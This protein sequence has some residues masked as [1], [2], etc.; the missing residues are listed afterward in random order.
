MAR[1]REHLKNAPIVEAVIDFRVVPRDGVSSLDFRELRSQVGAMYADQ[2]PMQSI[3]AKFGLGPGRFTD[4]R[5]IQ[6]IGVLF[7]GESVVAQFRI[8]G[9]TFNKLAPYTSWD[10]VFAEALRLWRIYVEAAKPVELTR[11]AVRYVNRLQLPNPAD[12][13]KYLEVPPALPAPISHRMQEYLTRFVIVDRDRDA[14][15]VIIQALERSLEPAV[16]SLLFDI[17]AF[18]D[19]ALAPDDSSIPEVFQRLRELKNEIFFATLT[20]TTVEMYA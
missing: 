10:E 8:D 1:R 11:V 7:K 19:D 12:L 4:S 13:S 2:N 3:E 6:D 15:A 14:S 20:E 16:M 17:D 9:F 5:E 18:R